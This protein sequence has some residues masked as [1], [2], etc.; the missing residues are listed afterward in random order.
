METGL[1]LKA[2]DLIY[3][4]FSHI[5]AHVIKEGP[6]LVLSILKKAF[7]ENGNFEKK[8]HKWEKKN[9]QNYPACKGLKIP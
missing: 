2:W 5:V 6:H 1:Q 4:P 3:D 9:I 8:I 7:F